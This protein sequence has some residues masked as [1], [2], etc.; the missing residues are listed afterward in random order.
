MTAIKN[1]LKKLE[2]AN[3]NGELC[4]CYPQHIEIYI[5][6]LR[7][8]ARTSDPVLTSKPIP[9]IC[10]DCNKPTEKNS[11]TVQL[12]DGTTKDRFPDEWKANRK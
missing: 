6:D 3:G 5:Q 7:E 8:D 10:P 4:A 2:T 11:I 9:E 1:R 12:V